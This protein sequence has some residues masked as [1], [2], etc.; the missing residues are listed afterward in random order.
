VYA[1]CVFEVLINAIDDVQ[2]PL[3]A[4]DLE[5]LAHASQRLQLRVAANV[6]VFDHDCQW[7]LD[8]ATSMTNWLTS[9]GNTGANAA[10][11]I[12]VGKLM[13]VCPTIATLADAGELT[14]NQVNTIALAVGPH[15]ALFSD[16]E[17]DL[18]PTLTHLSARETAAV[19]EQWRA[20]ADDTDSRAP[21][22]FEARR[23][24]LSSGLDGTVS[25]DAVLDS[26]SGDIVKRALHIAASPDGEG[27]SRTP[28][29]ARHDALVDICQWF[30]LHANDEPASR[31]R[32]VLELAVPF[33]DI[34]STCAAT[35]VD[36]Q[37]F[38][39]SDLAA[40]A[41]DCTVHRVIVNPLGTI[42]DYGRAARVVPASMFRALVTRD[43]GCRHPGCDRPAAW[44]DAHHIIEWHR[45]GRTDLANMLL[46]CRRHHRLIHTPGWSLHYDVA[47]NT[48]TV[49]SPTGRRWRD[50]CRTTSPP[51]TPP[52]PQRATCSRM[53]QYEQ[54]YEAQLRNLAMRSAPGVVGVG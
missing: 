6:G 7:A 4:D 1:I 16:I 18:A 50:P 17:A 34:K 12:R 10:M 51:G 33:D 13:R 19:M 38:P 29:Q 24:H 39:A 45:G 8:G 41:C 49:T 25:L 43:K 15:L 22:A 9:R 30:L 35:T 42:V 5:V 31:N 3:C 36:G 44:C 11:L 26:A 23:L 14:T 46:L 40:A 21:N 52:P 27:E 2:S 28:A 20:A 48:V 37:F 54:P 32:P 47:T 53:D